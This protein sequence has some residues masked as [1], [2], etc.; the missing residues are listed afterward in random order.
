MARCEN[1]LFSSSKREKK[2]Q[3]KHKTK[4]VTYCLLTVRSSSRKDYTYHYVVKTLNSIFYINFNKNNE[5][6]KIFLYKY[7][8]FKHKEVVSNPH[9]CSNSLWKMWLSYSFHFSTR[10]LP[11]THTKV[12]NIFSQNICR[13]GQQ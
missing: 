4:C 11:S 10:I 8:V 9:V 3:L 2:N 6:L 12:F 1:V 13:D 5:N 7:R